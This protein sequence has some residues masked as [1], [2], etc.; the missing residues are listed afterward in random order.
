M[1]SDQDPPVPQPAAGPVRPP[2]AGLAES[3][4]VPLGS[5]ADVTPQHGQTGLLLELMREMRGQRESFQE[6]QRLAAGERK[7]EHRWRMLFQAM[8]FGLPVLLG[9]VYFLFFLSST[10][11]RWGPFGDVVGVVRIEG[12]ISSTDRASADSIV[13]LLEKAFANPSVKAVVL[14]I[15]S[16]GGAPVEAERIYTAIGTLK[17]K[18]QKPV[19]A[20]INNL[21]ASAAFLIAL[22]ADKI[23]AGRY[24]LVGS[25][26][27]IMA[28]WQLDRAIAKYDISQRV[29]ASGK[30]KSFLNPFTPVTPEVD[31]KAKKLVD[32]LGTYFLD[33]V[34]ARRGAQLKAGIDVATGEVWAGPEAKEIGLVDAVGTLDDYVANTWGVQTYDFGPSTQGL[35]L[36]GR[37]IQDALVNSVQRLAT[38]G[39]VVR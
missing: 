23:V 25:I 7:S 12:P 30:L 36:L 1:N 11:F 18:H 9:L 13:P 21:G 27:A 16:P 3:I 24:S 31:E 38:M 14:S 5:Q 22:H 2:A 32:Q 26:G 39:V 17:R 28:P 34:K 4:D 29:Y 15:D 37:T 6:A 20:V 33:E 19:V 10:G 8:V 35:Q